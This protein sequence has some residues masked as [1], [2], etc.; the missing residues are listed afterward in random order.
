VAELLPAIEEGVL[1]IDTLGLEEEGDTDV[2]VQRVSDLIANVVAPES[3]TLPM[4][5]DASG[6][7]LRA[8]QVEGML[9]SARLEPAQQ[10]GVASQF[11]EWVPA[12]PNASI[13]RIL[14][15]RS[16]MRES[17][18]KY[19]GAVIQLTKEV[20][21]S[22]VD[23]SFRNEV[24]DLHRQCVQP[25]LDEIDQLTHDLGLWETITRTAR[26]GGGR[27]ATEFAL[28]FAVAD[29]VGIPPL[30]IAAIPPAV[31]VA[32][33]ILEQRKE[34]K[35]SQRANQFYFLYE[36]DRTLGPGA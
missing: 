26:S 23:D 29:V 5:D 8:M 12:F 33:K 4:F 7:F 2:L 35:A 28:A 18:I 22:P 14:V 27:L 17:L 34:T 24:A 6:D 30:L 21:A 32:G 9:S 13:D 19:R 36:A 25:A 15:A 1:K 31:D 10:I 16:E 11:I 3:T 20:E